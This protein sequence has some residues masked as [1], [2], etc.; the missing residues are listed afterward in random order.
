MINKASI[1]ELNLNEC[2]AAK[3]FLQSRIDFIENSEPSIKNVRPFAIFDTKYVGVIMLVP[4]HNR[5]GNLYGLAQLDGTTH[6]YVSMYSDKLVDASSMVLK[7][8]SLSATLS[9]SKFS[10]TK[11]TV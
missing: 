7:L 4:Q 9:T 6:A 3:E 10:I 1:S 8:K 2:L 11:D 5:C